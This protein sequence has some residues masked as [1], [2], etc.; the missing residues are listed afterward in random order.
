MVFAGTV[1]G[2]LSFGYAADKVG[3]KFG[4]MLAAL[5][6]IVFATLSAGAYAGGSI[7]GMLNA[8]SA[9]RFLLGIGIGGEY[10]A[11]SVAAS[12]N[13]EAAGI[14]KG[15]QHM[16]FALATNVAIDF[17]FVISAF[18]PLVWLYIL[19]EG[20]LEQYVPSLLACTDLPC[21]TLFP[22]PVQ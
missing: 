6:I 2:M 12:E 8:L 18:V 7:V 11:G 14:K 1:V 19:G 5:I 21:H 13:T 3:R 16:L 4:M 10:P 9:Y 20:R 22:L 15:R 17:G